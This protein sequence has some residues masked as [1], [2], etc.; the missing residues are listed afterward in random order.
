MAHPGA[1]RP[2]REG[3][4]IEGASDSGSGLCEARG[5]EAR[6]WGAVSWRTGAGVLKALGIAAGAGD[7]GAGDI[8]AG[9][10]SDGGLAGGA[11]KGA[12]GAESSGSGGKPIGGKATLG[13]IV[14]GGMP[15]GGSSVGTESDRGLGATIRDASNL[16]GSATGL[17]GTWPEA[18]ATDAASSIES[19]WI[20]SVRI[21]GSKGSVGGPATVDSP[22]STG[23]DSTGAETKGS[24]TKKASGAPGSLGPEASRGIGISD[25]IS[26]RATRGGRLGASPPSGPSASEDTTIG[27]AKTAE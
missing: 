3:G 24:V 20:E 23:A 1:C 5:C 8:G 4:S 2:V 17:A 22:D 26:G 10:P 15:P 13:G 9:V 7:I 6:G 14:V 25:G 21:D 27:L 11:E 16:G 18:N 12:A 19:L